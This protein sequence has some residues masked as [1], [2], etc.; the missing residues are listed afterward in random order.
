M[1]HARALTDDSEDFKG[2]RVLGQV[3]MTAPA[4]DLLDSHGLLPQDEEQC[5]AL[6]VALMERCKVRG[7]YAIHQPGT[8]RLLSQT[9]GHNWDDPYLG[10]PP[11]ATVHLDRVLNLARPD[12]ITVLWRITTPFLKLSDE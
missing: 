5:R 8:G 11:W 3:H 7:V 2:R 12:R 6:C 1:M 9:V 10:K 4:L